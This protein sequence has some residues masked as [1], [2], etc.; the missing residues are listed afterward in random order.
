MLFSELPESAFDSLLQPI[1]Q[2]LHTADSVIYEAET[3][4]NFIYSIRQ[5][6]VKLV[7]TSQDGTNRIIRLLGPGSVIGLE[8]LDGAD[9]YHHTA[10]AQNQVDLC[11]I[12]V[13]TV[14]QLYSLYPDLCKR[15]ND[16]LQKQLDLADQWIV[17][18][19]SGTAKQ[20][21]AHLLLIL[22]EIFADKNGDFT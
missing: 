3:H 21:V 15:V 18:L 13:V 8:L 11:R 4:K 20:R 1:D 22:N 2:Y 17:T 12:P 19:G 10:V 6:M 5:G 14:K 16:Q 9:S 7:N